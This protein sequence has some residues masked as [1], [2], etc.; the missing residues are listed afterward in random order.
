MNVLQGDKDFTFRLPGAIQSN[1]LE[2]QQGGPLGSFDLLVESDINLIS[3]KR[4]EIFEVEHDNV[5]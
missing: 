1:G 2:V 4:D 3:F 5:Y